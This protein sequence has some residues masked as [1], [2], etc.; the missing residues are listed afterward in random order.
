MKPLIVI[1]FKNY[2]PALGK[3][4]LILAKK[5]AAVKQQKYQLAIAP[6]LLLLEE[7]ITA[8]T[9]PVFAQHVDALISG[10]RTG[11]IS[12]KELIELRAAGAILNHSE[13]KLPLA[14]LQ[15]TIR[16]CKKSKL[17]VIVCAASL[18]ELKKIAPL[19][20]D[21]I[22]YEP[23]ELIGGGVSVTTAKPEIVKKAVELVGKLSPKTKVLCGA[24]IQGREDLQAA[25]RLGTTGI[26]ISHVVVQ[27]RNPE[28]VLEKML[29]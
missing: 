2:P 6:S 27:A 7:V 3:K 1:N 13:R 8:V 24:G 11:N 18:S 15:K 5:L 28:R 20:P 19:Y 17:K 9:I 21:F 26:L 10:P 22:A 4:G 16:L 14:V 12:V 25:L 23:P 29:E